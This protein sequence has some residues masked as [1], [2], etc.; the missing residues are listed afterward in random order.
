MKLCRQNQYFGVKAA[1]DFIRRREGGAGVDDQHADRVGAGVPA[2][3]A[4]RLGAAL[5]VAQGCGRN[6]A[7]GQG[8]GG[9]GPKAVPQR[10]A[11]GRQVEQDIQAG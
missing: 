10:Q 6:L 7:S 8:A 11:L 3:A 9:L 2:G 4:C 1:Q 5:C